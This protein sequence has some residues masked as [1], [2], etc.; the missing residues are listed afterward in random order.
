MADFVRS[1]AEPTAEELM[2]HARLEHP[3]WPEVV[4]QTW[5]SAKKRLDPNF[6]TASPFQMQGWL[7]SILQITCPVLVFSADPELGGLVTPQ[8]AAEIRRLNPRFTFAHIPGVG[9]HIRFASY[10]VYMDHFRRFL[11][12]GDRT[13]GRK[14]ASRRPSAMPTP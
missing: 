3:T 2:D 11:E 4:I 7:E 6:L 10:T 1:L 12:G 9:H 13:G 5:C 14:P 8:A